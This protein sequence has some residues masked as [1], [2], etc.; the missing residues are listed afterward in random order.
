MLHVAGV[1]RGRRLEE[2]HL[3]L[4]LR[5]RSMLHTARDDDE[6]A[7]GQL[8]RTIA[9]INPESAPQSEKHLVGVVV[10]VPDELPLELDQ[11]DLLA[12][13]SATILGCHWSENRANFQ[14]Y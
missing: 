3:D 9:K 12:L 1:A 4:L 13:S 10:T 6:I 5:H 2:E 7:G 11:L 8:D 14:R